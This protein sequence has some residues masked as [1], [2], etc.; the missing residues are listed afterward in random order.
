MGKK[1]QILWGFIL[2][3]ILAVS[4]LYS[5]AISDAS[6][7]VKTNQDKL[8]TL[9]IQGEI[10]PAQPA[11]S[12][13]TTWNGKPKMA[14]G[15]G[16][17]NYNLMLGEKIFGWASGD[18]ATMGV[19]T[20]GIGEDRFK[21][22]WLNYSAVGNEARI[23]SGKAVGEKGV[24]IGKFG[25]Y[26][27]LH[28]AA[29][30]LEKLAI[31]DKLQVK[32]CGTGLKIDGFDDVHAHGFSP[33]LLERMS[34]RN[35]QGRLEVPVVKVI[36]AEIVGQGS[37]GSSLSGNWHIQTCYPPDIKQYGLD[38]LRFGDLVLLQDI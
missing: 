32:A 35:V 6:Q 30:V 24:V 20:V 37:G 16:G 7:A 19:A 11:T 8:L 38:G 3:F 12:Y 22:G 13:T 26:V 28:F 18:R 14:I 33:R 29:D 15:M 25:R 17:I 34:I 2:C 27:Q 23:L 21:A 10:T 36:P 31:G 1:S 9:A 4:N 5:A